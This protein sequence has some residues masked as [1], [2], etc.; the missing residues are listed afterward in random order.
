MSRTIAGE[1]DATPGTLFS[2]GEHSVRCEATDHAGNTGV[3]EFTFTVGDFT[4]PEL[5]EVTDVAVSAEG[6]HGA[7]VEYEPPT[8]T[9]NVDVDLEVTCDPPSGSTFPLGDT[10]VT[11]AATDT[12]GNEATTQFTVTVTDTGAPELSQ[13]SDMLVA[14]TG[15]DG[16]VVEFDLPTASDDVDTDLEV[17]CVPSSGSVF[18]IGVTTVTCEV[19]DQ[20]GNPASVSFTVT[21]QDEQAPVV[22]PP[23]DVTAAA[24]SID[25]ATVT[26]G[27]GSAV[28]VV[29]GDLP[30]SC[31]PASGSLFAIGVTT[32]TCSATDAEGN[33]GTAIFTVTVEDTDAPLVEA[34]PVVN[35]EAT[36]PL[37]VV[38]YV[39]PQAQDAIYGALAT[40]CLPA[41]GS[42]FAVG[43]TYVTCTATDGSGNVGSTS[44]WVNV[45]DTTAP[46]LHGADITVNALS[47]TGTVVALGVTATDLVD[48][49][50]PPL[51][52]PAEGSLF[53]PE[54]VTE[55][56]CTATDS[57]G[58]TASLTITVTVTGTVT[59]AATEAG[60]TELQIAADVFA[61]GDYVVVDPGGPDEEVRLVEDLGSIIFAAPL[62]KAHA[63]GTVVVKVSPP[64]LGDVD[65]PEISPASFGPLTK[66]SSPSSPVTCADAGVGVQACLVPP[67]STSTTGTF[68][69]SVLAW[70]Y[71]GNVTRADVTYTVVAASGRLGNTGPDDAAALTGWASAAIL[72]GLAL[73]GLGIVRRR[74]AEPSS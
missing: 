2:M 63:A 32:V 66:G 3:L 1:C 19:E 6:P 53:A 62:A 54:S 38:H 47:Q 42:E 26:Y 12:A 45:G 5:S 10:T 4:G 52:S 49:A 72:T 20:A 9:D 13:P 30:I 7:V 21:V 17:A 43:S 35:L 22:T 61:P 39:S 58:N 18:A 59:T 11:C 44:F 69:L 68:T 65:G 64:P 16:A 48:G 57:E 8:A 25:G 37:T 15:P 40:Q 36:G 70:D 67:V 41:S 74:G 14:P 71:N 33:T 55:V 51:C 28:D 73:L 60:E 34:G 29:D 27:G 56:E 24:E 23:D 50:V 46:T 31:L